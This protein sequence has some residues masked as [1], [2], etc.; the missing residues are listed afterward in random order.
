MRAEKQRPRV[1]PWLTAK[2]VG[3]VVT[4][5]AIT[6]AFVGA[7][8][9]SATAAETD[10]SESL[11]QMIA[12]DLLNEV[13]GGLT[14]EQLLD[15]GVTTSGNPSD[16][17]ANFNPLNI[18]A[19]GLLDVNLP[20]VNLP[21]LKTPD[22]ENGLLDLGNAGLVNS[23]GH[24]PTATSSKAAAG[25]V[26]EDGAINV[27]GINEGSTDFASVDLIDLLRQLNLEGVSDAIVDGLSLDL[28]ALASVAEENAGVVTSDYVVAGAEIAVSSPLA[29]DLTTALGGASTNLGLAL[30]EALGSEGTLVGALNDI[31]LDINLGLLAA[32]VQS[33]SVGVNGLDAALAEVDELLT[34]TI[35]DDNGLLSL[36]L[37][38]GDITIDLSKLVESGDLNGLGANTQL[39]NATTLTLITNAAAD[40]LGNVVTDVVDPV[41]N[42]INSLQVDIELGVNLSV[43]LVA[44]VAADVSINAPLGQLLGTAE[45]FDT[46]LINI[47]VEQGGLLGALLG[48]LGIELDGLINALLTPVLNGVLNAV[49]DTVG[50]TVVPLLDNLEEVISGP[51]ASL[52]NG[53]SP[54]F[55]ALNQVVQVTIN[56]Q[57][58]NFESAELGLLGDESFTVNALGI[59]LLPA[60]NVANVSLAS[61]TVRA[62]DEAPVYDTSIL[63]TPGS[64]EQGGSTTISGEGFAPLE[65]VTITVD[66]VEVGTV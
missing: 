28:G 3:G 44:S 66:G 45:D 49:G 15:V 36:D 38:A 64:V 18:G 54:V 58:T 40:L 30:N 48:A 27:D 4:A 43:P 53:L 60:L 6:A 12:S 34:S 55:A 50:L 31:D 63:V 22:Q 29:G 23:F 1:K 25:V 39:L 5:T 37:G 7:G 9:T 42:I 11:A 65:T 61:S 19:L 20:T 56:E 57:P 33:G 8:A 17:G 41:K 32:T 21:L 14:D 16:E 46:D 13:I 59:S 35:G 47:E 24:S 51:L 2:R 62:L 26:T 52:L 10:D